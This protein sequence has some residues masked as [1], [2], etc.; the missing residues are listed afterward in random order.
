MLFIVL[1][2]FNAH[3]GLIN[4]ELSQQA[5]ETG[6]TIEVQLNAT[7]FDVFDAFDFNLAF[8]SSVFAFDSTSLNSD[9]MSSNPFGLLE[10]NDIGGKIAFSF[11]DIFTPVTASEFLLASFE[12]EAIAPGQ[13]LISLENVNFYEPFPSFNMLTVDTTSV[14]ASVPETSSFA[15]FAMALGLM[16]MRRTQKNS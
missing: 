5:V 4:I 10:V 1:F 14:T 7:G 12:F 11:V 8:D 6:E 15:L 16:Q 9:L 13:S 3:A 2:A